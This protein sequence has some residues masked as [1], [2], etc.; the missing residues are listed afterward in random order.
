MLMANCHEGHFNHGVFCNDVRNGKQSNIIR[1]LLLVAA[2][3]GFTPMPKLLQ[4]FVPFINEKASKL[5][6]AIPSSVTFLCFNKTL[7]DI[8]WKEL[9][10]KINL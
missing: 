4:Y 8:I 3:T 10:I 6:K 7:N 1:H 2:G 5:N 9:S